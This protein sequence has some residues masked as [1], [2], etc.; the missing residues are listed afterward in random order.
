[1]IEIHKDVSKQELEAELSAM[2]TRTSESSNGKRKRE[3]GGD[4]SSDE[5]GKKIKTD[6]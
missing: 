4:D 3:E 1:L 5:S 6:E 2:K